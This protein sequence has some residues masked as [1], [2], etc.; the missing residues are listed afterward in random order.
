MA[1]RA[2][3]ITELKITTSEV[4]HDD[5][6]GTSLDTVLAC[7]LPTLLKAL[8]QTAVLDLQVTLQGMPP[9]NFIMHIDGSY[10]Q[11]DC[12]TRMQLDVHFSAVGSYTT[13]HSMP[14]LA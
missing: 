9:S 8:G 3:G 6:N 1:A 7:L 13:W 5:V 2:K 14:E 4:L 12:S 10:S 11:L